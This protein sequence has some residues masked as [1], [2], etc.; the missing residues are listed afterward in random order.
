MTVKDR[1]RATTEAIS[2]TMTEVRP[3]TLPP[4]GPVRTRPPREPRRWPDW[5]V[6]L[7]AAAVVVALALT[8]VSIREAGRRPSAASGAEAGQPGASVAG[9]AGVPKYYAPPSMTRAGPRSTTRAP[10]TRSR[11]S[12]ARPA[13]ASGSPPSRRPAAS[14]SS[15]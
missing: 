10:L 13:A 12:S 6:P 2:G 1:L 5:A 15:A 7:T 14:R 9:F 3:L 8:L 4:E 11:W